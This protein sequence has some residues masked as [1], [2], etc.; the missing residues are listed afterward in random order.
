[1][2][3]DI[4]VFVAGTCL[5]PLNYISSIAIVWQIVLHCIASLKKKKENLH[6][7]VFCFVCLLVGFCLALTSL[8]FVFVKPGSVWLLRLHGCQP[9][10]S[11]Y[12]W[13]GRSR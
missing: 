8:F 3:N 4:E 1:M 13:R 5:K 2:I 9:L 6:H 10:R 12:L 7:A 11:F